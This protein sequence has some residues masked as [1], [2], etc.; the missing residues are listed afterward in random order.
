MEP[1]EGVCREHGFGIN[2]EPCDCL[3]PDLCEQCDSEEPAIAHMPLCDH[4]IGAC[5][6]ETTR[7]CN[8]CSRLQPEPY[9]YFA[10]NEAT[11]R[12]L[13]TY[14]LALSHLHFSK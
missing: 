6:A 3:Q 14:Y 10:S 9:T 13:V 4:G 8:A 1:P 12:R 5:C 7:C 11:T 2:P